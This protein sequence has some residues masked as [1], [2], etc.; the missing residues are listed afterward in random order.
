MRSQSHPLSRDP[1][2]LVTHSRAS[3]FLHLANL[4]SWCV[5]HNADSDLIWTGFRLGVRQF[6]IRTGFEFI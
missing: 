4:V 6:A 5:H 2:Q 3:L 1:V